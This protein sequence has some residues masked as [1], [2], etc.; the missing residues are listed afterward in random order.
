MTGKK[1]RRAAQRAAVWCKAVCETEDNSSSSLR[2]N[3]TGCR[4]E[5]VLPLQSDRVQA[6]RKVGATR[7]AEWYRGEC[8]SSLLCNGFS[9]A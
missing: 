7:Q 2:L 8:S 6:R 5:R 4:I 9:V 1:L 3:P